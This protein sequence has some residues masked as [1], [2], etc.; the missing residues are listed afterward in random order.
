MCCSGRPQ[1]AVPMARRCR[2]DGQSSTVCQAPFGGL[3]VR[4]L[5]AGRNVLHNARKGRPDWADPFR[6]S[7]VLRERLP[8]VCDLR[9][10]L[11]GVIDGEVD[12]SQCELH[13]QVSNR[14]LGSGRRAEDRV[15][16]VVDGHGFHVVTSHVV[17]HT[18]SAT[19]RAI[20]AWRRQSR[21]SS[22][23]CVRRNSVHASSLHH[24]EQVTS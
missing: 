8:L 23:C 13:A 2:A 17:H 15:A 10:M 1:S 18:A 19:E 4:L 6:A 7:L 21:S 9:T 22:S 20:S 5:R 12:A 11:R 24:V 14:N 16:H 3:G